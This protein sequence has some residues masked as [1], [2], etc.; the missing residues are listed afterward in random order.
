MLASIGARTRVR[1]N[2][3]SGS[4]CLSIGAIALILPAAAHLASAQSATPMPSVESSAASWQLMFMGF[5]DAQYDRQGG[6]RGSTQAGSVSWGMLMATHKLAG[7][8][9]QLRTM[10]SLD[11]I[12]VGASG[13][14]ELLQSG[15][16]YKGM[17]LHD[18]QHPHDALMELGAKYRHI[19]SHGVGV[20]FYAAPVGEPALGP[21]AFMMRPSAMDNPIAPIGHH[22]QDATHVSF[23]VLSAG[24]FTKRWTL[25]G[26][27]FNGREPDANRW[28]IDPLRLDSWSGRLTYDATP[29]WS[30]AASYGYLKSPTESAPSV[31]EHRATLS[32]SHGV[33]FGADGQWSTA[34][35]WGANGQ[36]G[37][38]MSGSVLAESE[39]SLDDRNSFVTR[40]EYVR[41]TA[42]DLALD[43]PPFTLAPAQ[44]FGVYAMS[45]GYVREFASW[46]RGTLG[47][48][49][50]GTVNAVPMSLRNAY[51]STTPVGAVLFVR[52]RPRR[53]KG[54]DM[55]G[56]VMDSDAAS[57]E[58]RRP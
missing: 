39:L 26:S 53:A 54:G 47:I 24:L 40:A 16:T 2:R 46:N 12:G 37:A 50:L 32:L 13:Y 15:E 43:A 20:S 49:L 55:A 7:G 25:D 35:I 51:G 42:D 6:A 19:I 14:P 29:H 8:E 30:L 44:T 3:S 41:K 52:L 28:N 1:R 38:S 11:A 4:R 10:I 34:L 45:L 27:W 33:Q 56:M 23:G 5:A 9:L 48:G 57:S 58:R 17:P 31:A 36:R 22:W 18:R 21:V